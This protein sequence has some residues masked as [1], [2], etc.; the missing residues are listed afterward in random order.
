MNS[1]ITLTVLN[2][3]QKTPKGAT[4]K[5]QV[6]RYERYKQDQRSNPGHTMK[7]HTYNPLTNVPTKYQLPTTL[8]FPKYSPDKAL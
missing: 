8:W 4:T 1:N 5:I 2:L 3:H 7:L 6:Q